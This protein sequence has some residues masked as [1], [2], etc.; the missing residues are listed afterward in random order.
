MLMATALAIAA[1]RDFATSPALEFGVGR[2][3]GGSK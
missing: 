3:E 1:P 2:Q